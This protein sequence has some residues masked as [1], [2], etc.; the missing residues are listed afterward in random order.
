MSYHCFTWCLLVTFSLYID[1]TLYSWSTIYIPLRFT[2][3]C[4]HNHVSIITVLHVLIS[5]LFSV[6]LW[7]WPFLCFTPCHYFYLVIYNPPNTLFTASTMFHNPLDSP[8][9]HYMFYWLLCNLSSILCLYVYICVY[10]CMCILSLTYMPTT[11][12]SLCVVLS[13]SPCS[14][15]SLNVFKSLNLAPISVVNLYMDS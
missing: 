10:L 6:T 14:I 7:C 15:T 9:Y 13:V 8:Y 12:I 5:H 1:V 2:H 11:S 3:I 4:T